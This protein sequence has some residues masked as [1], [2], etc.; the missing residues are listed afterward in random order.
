MCCLNILILINLVQEKFVNMDGCLHVPR[1]PTLKKG[2]C[3]FKNLILQKICFMLIYV[4][5]HLIVFH[6]T[7][8]LLPSQK[9]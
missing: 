9:G 2:Q 7:Y 3:Y 1:N 8:M 6:V 4:S 5:V